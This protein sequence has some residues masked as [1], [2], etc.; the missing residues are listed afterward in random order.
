MFGTEWREKIFEDEPAAISDDQ[1]KIAERIALCFGSLFPPVLMALLCF[2]PRIR[3]DPAR[4]IENNGEVA[5]Q[6]RRLVERA[7]PE[8]YLQKLKTD[9]KSWYTEGVVNTEW[10][11]D[12]K[13][14]ITLFRTV[15]LDRL[16]NPVRT[17]TRPKVS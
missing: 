1:F 6:I 16:P 5:R 14:W 7:A 13:Q 11:P 9:K 12:V 2:E 3:S 8:N 4:G 15:I 10:F 17:P